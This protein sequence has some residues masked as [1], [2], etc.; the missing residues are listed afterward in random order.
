MQP[1]PYN[2]KPTKC[3]QHELN[4]YYALNVNDFEAIVNVPTTN[5]TKNDECKEKKKHTHRTTTPHQN[6]QMND[7]F[8][9]KNL[10]FSNNNF[11]TLCQSHFRIAYGHFVVVVAL[12]KN[13]HEGNRKA[14]QLTIVN[15]YVFQTVF[16]TIIQTMNKI[17][18]ARFCLC[19]CWM[20]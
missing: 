10:L 2:T 13:V 18:G 17:F 7:C 19:R 3:L 5:R 9:N 20:H 15:D 4:E 8:R 12:S 1:N 14:T 6:V 16:I 11:M